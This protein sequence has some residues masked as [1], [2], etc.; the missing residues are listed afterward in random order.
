[1]SASRFL[2]GLGLRRRLRVC[3]IIKVSGRYSDRGITR[4]GGRPL[5]ATS[6]TVTFSRSAGAGKSQR[7]VL[8]PARSVPPFP[9]ILAAAPLASEVWAEISHHTVS[10]FPSPTLDPPTDAVELPPSAARLLLR[11]ASS[12]ASC[13]ALRRQLRR[14][15]SLRSPT[16][17]WTAPATSQLAMR[18][19]IPSPCPLYGIFAFIF[20]LSLGSFSFTESF[21]FHLCCIINIFAG[22]AFFLNLFL[23]RFFQSSSLARHI[24]FPSVFNPRV[25]LSDIVAR[26]VI[27]MVAIIH[28]SLYRDEAAPTK[29]RLAGGSRPTMTVINDVP[30][31][32]R[33][34]QTCW[35]WSN[36]KI[37]Y[38]LLSVAERI[39]WRPM[40]HSWPIS[41][42]V[43]EHVLLK[44][45]TVDS[46]RGRGFVYR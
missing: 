13:T 7:W 36:D 28:Q 1:M 5:V 37:N 29:T 14:S 16:P 25:C 34:K 46:R 43:G 9:A 6:E 39:S 44:D 20:L 8:S 12:V 22:F 27:L 21:F 41:G 19:P 42:W 45:S 33:Q 26:S 3:R 15:A 31:C 38:H 18:R 11:V 32:V 30:S 17:H 23:F 24:P 4:S 35:L 40:K 2:S 10:S